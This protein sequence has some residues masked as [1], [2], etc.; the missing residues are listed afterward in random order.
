[1]YITRFQE[2]GYRA[3]AGYGEDV[4]VVTGTVPGVMIAAESLATWKEGVVPLRW[5]NTNAG[6][7]AVWLGWN[8]RIAG[9]DT[10]KT[11]R[12][13]SYSVT[14]TDSIRSAWQVGAGSAVVFS[15]AA[16]SVTPGPRAAAK[17]TTKAARD[18]S[19]KKPAPRPARTPPKKP[20]AA[21]SLPLELSIELVDAAGTAAR[22]PLGRYGVVRRPIEVT[23]L[24][25]RGRDKTNFASQSELIPQ[26]FTV[27]LADFRVVTPGF[28]PSRLATI[29]WVFDGTRA[30]TVLLTDIGLSNLDPAFLAPERRS[31]P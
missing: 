1:M 3:L 8:N 26:T 10:T 21:D 9:T 6:H 27:P 28:D 23:V 24:K 4:N 22:L 12:P 5:Q 29:R 30:G 16:T 31:S 17:D 2:S 7:S 18:S 15:L 19:S 25:R 13:A 20:T 11:G 14:L